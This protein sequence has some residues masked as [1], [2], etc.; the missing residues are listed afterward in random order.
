MSL[1]HVVPVFA[2]T[3]LVLAMVPG[4]GMAM[5][6]RQTLTGGARC[7]TW[8][9]VGNA[10]GLV[11][12]GVASSVG[13]SQVF[14]HSPLAY[15][16]LKYAGVAYLGYLSLSTLVSLRQRGGA[17]D[18]NGQ[19]ATRPIAAYRLGLVTNLTNVKAAVFAVAFI[20]QFVPRSFP[21]GAGIVVLA[22]VQSLVSLGWYS[23]LVASVDRAATAL[24]RPGVRRVLTGISAIGLLTLAVVLLFS[25]PR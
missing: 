2:L 25:S 10:S 18:T 1:L 4:Q 22:L 24:S 19:A 23:A 14:A 7:A 5:V 16:I 17:F 12:W 8:S 13:L 11:V 15:N 3:A 6:L 21:L 20:P 9:V